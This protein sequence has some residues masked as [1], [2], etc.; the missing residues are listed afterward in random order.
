MD[1]FDAAKELFGY[2]RE[3]FFFDSELRLKREYQEQDMRVKQFILY[4]EDVRDLTRLTTGKMDSYLVL[5]LLLLGC[6]FDLL[7]HGVLH[8]RGAAEQPTWLLWLYVNLVAAHSFA[9]RL[10]TQYVR[11]PVPN[12]DQLDAARAYA[13]EFEGGG[14]TALL[15]MP[16]FS[17]QLDNLARAAGEDGDVA[18]AEA[19][20]DTVSLALARLSDPNPVSTLK[21]VRLYRDLQSNWQA[22][23]AYARAC[24]ALGTYTLIHAT[25]YYAIGLLVVEMHAPWPALGS[26]LLLPALAWLLI[27][28]DIYFGS[29]LMVLG[30]LALMFGPL[31]AWVAT[32]LVVLPSHWSSLLRN[33]H[34]VLVPVNFLLH[35]ALIASIVFVASADRSAD[36][37]IALPTRFRTVL[38]LDVF[39]WLGG[40]QT[41]SHAGAERSEDGE[42]ASQ[43]GNGP[44]GARSQPLPPEL[45]ESL[46]PAPAAP[47]DGV[48]A[49]GE[50]LLVAYLQLEFLAWEGLGATESLA[51]M[52]EL[53]NEVRGL[54][55]DFERVKAVLTGI[56]AANLPDAQGPIP[57]LWL[58]LAWEGSVEYFVNPETGEARREAPE[59]AR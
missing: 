50:Q 19:P 3:N 28:L 40:P 48:V 8:V 1:L 33:V 57:D 42:A 32:T 53:A 44:E 26:S 13:A 22:H 20:G 7:V 18:S 2:N 37:S 30:A 17:R 54:R 46:K 14:V 11:L 43:Q 36:R 52:P 38:Y 15:R 23:D 39:G 51:A 47:I 5:N 31:L 25:A 49:G 55:A 21:H 58:R 59:G 24:L 27:R 29:Y 35:V 34:I 9:V 41:A 56:D 6:C 45:M 4:R 10:L 12:Q 16:V